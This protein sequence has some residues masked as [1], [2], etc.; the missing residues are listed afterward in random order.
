[1]SPPRVHVF[2]FALKFLSLTWKENPCEF[3]CNNLKNQIPLFSR[4]EKHTDVPYTLLTALTNLPK[5]VSSVTESKVQQLQPPYYS[6]NII[7]QQIL[8]TNHKTPYSPKLLQKM[9]KFRPGPTQQAF[10]PIQ[11]PKP[12]PPVLSLMLMGTCLTN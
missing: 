9:E 10:W 1:M 3:L 4:K 7:L 6:S 2:S 5:K 11:R 12:F 8:W